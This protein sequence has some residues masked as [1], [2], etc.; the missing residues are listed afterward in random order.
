M[1]SLELSM[2]KILFFI[3]KSKFIRY[4]IKYI[5]ELSV[6]Y[7][8]WLSTIFL[9]IMGSLFIVSGTFYFVTDTVVSLM[10]FVSV[11]FLS[12]PYLLFYIYVTRAA[13]LYIFYTKTDVNKWLAYFRYSFD[14]KKNATRRS[15]FQLASVIVSYYNGKFQNSI[16]AAEKINITQLRKPTGTKDEVD[17]EFLL[18]VTLIKVSAMLKNEVMF[19]KYYS[20]LYDQRVKTD[21]QNDSRANLLIFCQAIKKICLEQTPVDTLDNW[22]PE[23][24]SNLLSLEKTYFQALNEQLK[25]NDTKAASLFKALSQENPDLFFV[26]EA[27][28]YLEE[29]K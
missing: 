28:Q 10:I 1:W 20:N 13:V 27:K 3:I 29:K 18:N 11:I 9:G 22:Q 8:Y 25:G 21:A 26:R 19:E 4:I 17:S 16:D 15:T 7:I 6:Q 14:R 24:L 2:K 12:I 23:F 5:S